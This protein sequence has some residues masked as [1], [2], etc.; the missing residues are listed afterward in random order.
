MELKSLV[1]IVIYTFSGIAGAGGLGAV[2]NLRLKNKFQKQI[3]NIKDKQ[4]DENLKN[5]NDKLNIL[6]VD[7]TEIKNKLKDQDFRRNLEIGMTSFLTELLVLKKVENT[8]IKAALY[9]GQDN[10]IILAKRI[11]YADFQIS[12]E[13]IRQN[14]YLLLKDIKG[15]IKINKLSKDV[16]YLQNLQEFLI[17]AVD[18]FIIEFA[19]YK[20]KIN[21]ERRKAFYESIM[22]LFKKIVINSVET[23]QSKQ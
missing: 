7:I 1:D 17:N 20:N 2:F 11:L 8:E 23:Y 13:Q 6:Q 12:A 19:N 10:L 22:M 4:Q 18:E 16:S 21:G 9:K 15:N 5:I 14:A 3:E